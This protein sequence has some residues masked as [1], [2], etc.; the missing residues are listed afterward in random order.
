MMMTTEWIESDHAPPHNERTKTPPHNE[1]TKTPPPTTVKMM[2]VSSSFPLN[3]PA[4][5]PIIPAKYHYMMVSAL[6][7]RI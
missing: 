5:T 1:R 6:M 2:S 3:L 4:L 7:A